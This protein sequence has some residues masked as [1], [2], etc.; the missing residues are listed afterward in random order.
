M[1][2]KK[3]NKS[4]DKEPNG[5]DVGWIIQMVMRFEKC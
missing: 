4:K 1:E 2:G 3:I 5:Q